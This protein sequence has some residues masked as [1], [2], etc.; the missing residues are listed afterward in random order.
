MRCGTLRC[1]TSF[2]FL[3]VAALL[4]S[5]ALLAGTATANSC[6]P[7]LDVRW[8]FL[9]SYDREEEVEAPRNVAI[10]RNPELLDISSWPPTTV[11]VVEHAVRGLWRP[12]TP[13]RPGTPLESI[14]QTVVTNDVID[15]EPP[16][17]LEVLSVSRGGCAG[18]LRVDAEESPTDDHTPNNRLVYAVYAGSTAA[19]AEEGLEPKAFALGFWLLPG[20]RFPWVAVSVL[21]QAGNESSRSKAFPVLDA[22]SGCSAAPKASGSVRLTWL[23]LGLLVFTFA[24]R[25]TARAFH[26]RI[27]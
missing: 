6:I 21:D 22:P 17:A 24:R 5:G 26:G 15:T 10:V 9:G 12:E 2:H 7:A 8:G 20:V 14:G 19:E 13:L 1:M 23:V 16:T 25:R 27:D 11:P 18:S 4:G 3:L